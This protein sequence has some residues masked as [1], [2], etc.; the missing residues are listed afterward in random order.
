MKPFS[1]QR[2]AF[3]FSI[4]VEVLLSDVILS[5]GFVTSRLHGSCF[6]PKLH[7]ASLASGISIK[8]KQKKIMFRP[9]TPFLFF[10]KEK[11]NKSMTIRGDSL[12]VL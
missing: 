7:A 11:K 5:S 8:N 6:C 4:L 2:Y 12:A 1:R 3:F 9:L 10:F